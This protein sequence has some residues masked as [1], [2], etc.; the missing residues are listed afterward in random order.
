[1]RGFNHELHE[2]IIKSTFYSLYFRDAKR[3]L[4]DDVEESEKWFSK[5]DYL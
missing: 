3:Y 1:M 2:G 4:M 5:G